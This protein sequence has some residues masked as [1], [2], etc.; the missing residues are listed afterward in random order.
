M[1]LALQKFICGGEH[2]WT[3]CQNET[4]SEDLFRE[5]S[6]GRLGLDR[7]EL[8]AGGV[9]TPTRLRIPGAHIVDL[10]AGGW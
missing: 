1:V 9:P 3:L 8:I 6:N 4:S 7:I 2:I 5:P 10:E